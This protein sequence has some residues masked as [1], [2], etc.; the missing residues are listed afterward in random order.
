[1]IED[2]LAQMT[3]EGFVVSNTFQV[4]EGDPSAFGRFPSWAVYLRNVRNTRTGHATA[5]TLEGALRAAVAKANE[6]PTY[7]KPQRSEASEAPRTVTPRRPMFAPS[8][9]QVTLSETATEEGEE[10]F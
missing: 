5:E 10:F 6:G 1:V 7:V 3:S 9:Q 2:I 8:P 4:G